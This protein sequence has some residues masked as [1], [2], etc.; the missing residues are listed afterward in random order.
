MARASDLTNGVGRAP[1]G[2]L[3]ELRVRDFALIEDVRLP[4]EPGL[5]VLT[6]ETGA[7][8]SLLIDAL[9]LVLGGRADPSAVRHGAP[10]SRVEARFVGRDGEILVVREVSAGGRS[11][12]RLDGE[13]IGLGRLAEVTGPLVEIHGQ[14]D[15]QRLLDP[16]R[17][18]DLLDGYAGLGALRA[19]VAETVERWRANRAA[20]AALALDPREL[21]RRIE[22][23]E[24]EAAEIAGAR[25]RIGEAEEIRERLAAAGHA[26]AIVRGA[27][28]LGDLL[29]GEGPSLLDLAGRAVVEAR[30]LAGYDRRF[31][32]LAERLAAVEAEAADLASEVRRLA[33]GVDHDPASLARLEARLS[34]IYGLLRRYGDDEA[35][36]IAYGERAAAEAARLR[37]ADAERARRAAAEPE[38]LAAVADA[39]AA[40]STARRRAAA[41]LAGAVDAALVELGFRPGTFSVLVGRRAAGPDEPAVEVEG[42]AVAFDATGIDEVV[43]AFAPNPGEPARPLARIA[44]GGE[45]SRVALA[46]EEVLAAVD[47]T[48][49]LVF[50]EIDAGIGGRSAE[51]VGQ[52][53]WRL[54]RRHAVLCVTHLA[55]I[56]A[57]ADHHVQIAK[58]SRGGR[59]ATEIR[60]LD[61]EDRLAELAAMLGG[62]AAGPAARASAEELLTRAEAWRA[63]EAGAP[64]ST[65]AG[66]RR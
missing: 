22:V 52:A 51:P 65:T 63:A 30:R 48:P 26:E 16:R 44:S 9:G 50:D 42:D 59:T 39:A 19:A 33:E 49:T 15:Q 34:E 3:R 13:P 64:A 28:T 4:V 37:D 1:D 8:K 46:I 31:E 38:L 61:R 2:R 23:A 7:G 58:T 11:S 66:R 21:A 6:G 17:Q 10:V 56:A 5:T 40:L 27:A 36:V 47:A 18:L 41:A 12:A 45:L 55:Q 14:H 57:Y 29:G 24:H 43:F 60:L 32:P 20:L 25:L 62:S 53:L 54:G 35:A